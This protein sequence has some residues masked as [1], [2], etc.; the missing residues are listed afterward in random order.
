[1][2]KKQTRH[3]EAIFEDPVRADID[4]RE[5]ESLLNAL[6]A[7]LS[8]GRGSRV[9]VALNGVRAV[10]HKPHP[11]KEIGKKTVRDIRGFLIEANVK[12]GEDEA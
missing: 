2:N 6:G 3:L 8:E 12:V 5:V 4:W 7:E 11:E 1:M 10:F 9:R